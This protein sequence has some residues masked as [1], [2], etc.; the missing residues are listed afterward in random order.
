MLKFQTILGEIKHNTKH[1]LFLSLWMFIVKKKGV[2][3]AQNKQHF[4]PHLLRHDK[5]PH[6]TRMKFAADVF[7]LFVKS[8]LNFINMFKECSTRQHLYLPFSTIICHSCYVLSN[9]LCIQRIKSTQKHS[10]TLKAK[11][12]NT[13]CLFYDQWDNNMSTCS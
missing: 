6:P 5:L 4:C 2:F 1:V 7:V 3:V 11:K 12:V 8:K 10:N 13:L 9:R